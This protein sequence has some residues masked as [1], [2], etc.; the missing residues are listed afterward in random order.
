MKTEKSPPYYARLSCGQW[1]VLNSRGGYE[2]ACGSRDQAA[3][4]AAAMN[5]QTEA[6]DQKEKS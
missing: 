3:L 1:Y 4:Y 2:L 5:R 6:N